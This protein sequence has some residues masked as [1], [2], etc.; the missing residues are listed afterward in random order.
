MKRS[1]TCPTSSSLFLTLFQYFQP[2]IK[3]ANPK[4][5]QNRNHYFDAFALTNQ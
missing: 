5:T 2:K 1:K 3:N 4:T